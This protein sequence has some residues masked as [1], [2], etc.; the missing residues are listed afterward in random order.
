MEVI[1]IVTQDDGGEDVVLWRGLAENF[2]DAVAKFRAGWRFEVASEQ[3]EERRTAVIEP[4]EF[5][6]VLRAPYDGSV[7]PEGDPDD[8][9]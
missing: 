4:R 7:Y 2:E 3:R 6:R 5:P 8:E 1:E 9:R